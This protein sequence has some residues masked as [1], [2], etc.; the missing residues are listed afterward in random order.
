MPML[1]QRAT[2]ARQHMASKSLYT[3]RGPNRSLWKIV[4]VK[5]RL[6][7]RIQDG[8]SKAVGHLPKGSAYRI[9]IR[10]RKKSMMESAK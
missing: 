1:F 4:E 8:D 6:L 9:G 5:P 10:M 7:W 3:I 2:E